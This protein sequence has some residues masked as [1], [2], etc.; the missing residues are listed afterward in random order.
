[1]ER[2]RVV[3]FLTGKKME[4]DIVERMLVKYD[5]FLNILCRIRCAF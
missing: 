3:T 5:A 2:E 4:P 1:M